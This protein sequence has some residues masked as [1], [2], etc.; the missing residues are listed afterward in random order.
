MSQE[1]RARPTAAQ[2]NNRGSD[3]TK[4]AM[5]KLLA[6]MLSLFTTYP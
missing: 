2:I 6:Q 3:T 1:S 5:R 4:L